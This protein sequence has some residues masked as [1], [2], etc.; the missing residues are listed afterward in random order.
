MVS[1]TSADSTS[2][3]S[4]LVALI[5]FSPQFPISNMSLNTVEAESRLVVCTRKWTLLEYKAIREEV[6]TLSR[7]GSKSG[8]QEPPTYSLEIIMISESEALKLSEI[9]TGCA[10]C[11]SAMLKGNELKSW[12]RRSGM[13]EISRLRLTDKLRSIKVIW[14]PERWYTSQF[15]SLKD[16]LYSCMRGE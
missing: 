3:T 7:G 12:E 2:F 13:R 8:L 15:P 5:S 16:S 1:R 10:A 9:I 6:R 14:N 4:L 11:G